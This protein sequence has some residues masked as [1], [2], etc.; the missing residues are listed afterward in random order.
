ML[1]LDISY[2]I[3]VHLTRAAARTLWLA[4]NCEFQSRKVTQYMLYD[5]TEGSMGFRARRNLYKHLH[6]KRN[7]VYGFQ[8]DLNPV[9]PEDFILYDLYYS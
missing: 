4:E 1:V 7:G 3:L 8:G 6:T 5:E 2:L 9:G